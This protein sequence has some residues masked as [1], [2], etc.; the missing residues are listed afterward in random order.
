MKP[1]TGWPF[2]SSTQVGMLRMPK[3][4]ASCCS[5]SESIFTSLKRPA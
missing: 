3:A 2:M 4:W 5:S 1:S